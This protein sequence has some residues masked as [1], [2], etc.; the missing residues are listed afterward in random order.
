MTFVRSQPRGH[1]KLPRL[2]QLDEEQVPGLLHRADI[3]PGLLGVRDVERRIMLL[4]R[5]WRAVAGFDSATRKTDAEEEDVYRF[6]GVRGP[7]DAGVPDKQAPAGAKDAVRLG[8]NACVR[9]SRLLRYISEK[10]AVAV[11][12]EPSRNGS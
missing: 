8:E 2:R 3:E 11:S 10:K 4:F 5:P 7:W 12:N 6:A 1:A 9:S